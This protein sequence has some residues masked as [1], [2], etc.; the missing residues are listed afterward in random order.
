[1][2]EVG[3]RIV[4]GVFAPESVLDLG[5]L[6]LEF[7]VSHTAMREAIKV[8]TAK[9]LVDARPKLGTYVLPRSLWN[10]LDPDVM[11]WRG[12]EKRL[13]VELAEVRFLMEPAAA[14]L[15]AGRA[16]DVQRSAMQAALDRME[17]DVRR[18]A[19]GEPVD[20]TDAADADIEFHATLAAASGNE[21]FEEFERLMW[22]AMRLRDVTILPHEHRGDFLVLHRNVLDAILDRNPEAASAAM[23]GLLT[24]SRF[25]YLS[26]DPD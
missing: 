4:T 19:A 20:W 15:A 2:D 14:S 6:E 5:A 12:R 22:P 21:L 16:T 24:Q 1:V 8:L 9:Q 23:T 13:Q 10:L 11:A 7:G 3:R 25:D 17:R 18:A 26:H